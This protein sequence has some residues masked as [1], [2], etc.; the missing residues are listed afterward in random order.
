[1]DDT[2]RSGESPASPRAAR[3]ASPAPRLRTP[4]TMDNS[5]TTAEVAARWPS[6][7]RGRKISARAASHRALDARACPD[8]LRAEFLHRGPVRRRKRAHDEV[9][10]RQGG[11]HVET[12]DLA[13]T[14]FHAV[15]IDGGVRIARHDD[16]HPGM[17]QK[18]SD[19]PNL[20]VRS[21]ESLPLQA[22]RLERA[23]PRQPPGAWKAAMIRRPRTST[24]V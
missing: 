4:S 20:E 2:G 8:E 16:P 14:A 6:G 7:T 22:D 15:A 21:S 24:E 1:M 13:K 12:Y 17:T 23:L 9:D 11:E 5:G 10:V 18:G 3:R 19:V